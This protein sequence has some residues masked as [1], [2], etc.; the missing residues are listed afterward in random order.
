MSIL[1]TILGDII[2]SRWEFESNIPNW[3]DCKFFTN[4][5]VYTDDTIQTIAVGMASISDR[6]FD[7]WLQYFGNKYHYVG[8]GIK[9]QEWLKNP[10]CVAR[11]SWGN[12]SAMRVASLGMIAQSIEEAEDL[13]EKSAICTHNSYEGIKGAQTISGCVFLAK[14]KFSKQSISQYANSKY[15]VAEYEYS[16]QR[17]LNDYADDYHFE[18]SCQKSVPVAIRCFLE[19]TDYESCIRNVLHVNGDT[20]TLCAMAGGIAGAFYGMSDCKYIEILQRYLEDE[21]FECVLK[22]QERTRI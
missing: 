10:L 16:P 11:D 9:F 6:N 21:L 2:G 22:I 17:P 5:S 3:R 12:G 1:G 7:S 18:A 20:D 15:P 14:T 13:A 4:D 8:F 19:S